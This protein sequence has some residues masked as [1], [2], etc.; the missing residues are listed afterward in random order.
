M[1]TG[2]WIQDKFIWGPRESGKYWV[3]NNWIWGP[4]NG[5]KYWI[6]DGYIWGRRK[7]E[8]F[9]LRMVTSMDLTRIPL[10]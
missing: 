4:R 3:E 8:S 10:G 6:Q 2:Y 9:G 7:A 5:G 1:H